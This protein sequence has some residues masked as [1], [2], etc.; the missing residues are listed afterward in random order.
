MNIP[1]KDIPEYLVQI[2]HL[3]KIGAIQVCKSESGQFLSHYF[4]TPK[5]NGKYRFIL[6]LK[7]LNKHIEP[8]HFKLEDFR[9]V[10]KLY[11][12]IVF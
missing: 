10:I 7:Q 5:H 4:L 2:K 11:T 8:P 3:L 1:K 12:E 9:T 6:N